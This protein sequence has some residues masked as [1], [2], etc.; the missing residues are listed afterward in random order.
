MRRLLMV[1]ISAI[2]LLVGANAANA[3][4]L[5]GNQLLHYCDIA[6]PDSTPDAMTGLCNGYIVGV[7]EFLVL[8]QRVCP[9]KTV[10]N[11]QVR[12]VVVAYLKAHPQTRDE[13]AATIVMEAANL[14][15][16]CK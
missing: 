5:S 16:H 9:S 8:M 6:A 12:D 15:F 14:P 13:P 10:T 3:L 4:V 11:Q 1:S 7:F 2:L